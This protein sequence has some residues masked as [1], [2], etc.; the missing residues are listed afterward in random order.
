MRLL[1]SNFCKCAAVLSLFLPRR[2]Q[3]TYFKPGFFIKEKKRPAQKRT[4]VTTRKFDVQSSYKG[5][6]KR[7][8]NINS[9]EVLFWKGFSRQPAGQQRSLTN[10]FLS[11]QFILLTDKLSCTASGLQFKKF[12]I[13]V[14]PPWTRYNSIFQLWRNYCFN[15]CTTTCSE[16][17]LIGNVFQLLSSAINI[18]HNPHVQFKIF[19]RCKSKASA[20]KVHYLNTGI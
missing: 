1:F 6:K 13:T 12:H 18:T 2:S 5:G 9:K 4:I 15:C 20:R 8:K 10:S 19:M 17:Q 7:K 3:R 14:L 16:T 11:Q